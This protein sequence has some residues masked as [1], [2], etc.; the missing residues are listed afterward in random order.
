MV[1]P[2]LLAFCPIPMIMV[3][4]KRYCT[5]QYHFTI[6]DSIR[7]SYFELLNFQLLKGFVQHH[8]VD[9]RNFSMQSE[10]SNRNH[11]LLCNQDL[12]N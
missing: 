11:F 12:V 10:K 1:E 7:K 8:T 9:P 2:N 5:H 3:L 6:L 4:E